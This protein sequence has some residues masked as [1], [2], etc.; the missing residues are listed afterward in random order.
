MGH[1]ISVE[2]ISVNPAKV[3]TV[4]NWKQHC[5]I[6]KI[7]SFLGL[8]RYYRKFIKGFSKIASPL[9]KLTQKD[10]K[11][12]WDDRCERS[13]QM[14][15][16]KLTTAPILA[17]PNGSGGYKVYT[18]TVKNGLGCVLMQHEKVIAYGSRQLKKHEQNYSIH[19]LELVT[20]VFTLKVWR[21][22]LYSE[23]FEIFTD[24]KSLQY[25]FYQKDLN[26]RQQR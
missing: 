24:H 4:K 10:V 23:K 26:M 19:D 13:F 22:Y 25:V 5:T 1:V 2:G 11:F 9:T 3:S 15:K 18:G 16:E 12:N 17:I 6:T 21:H 8:A 20:V 7:K 14:F